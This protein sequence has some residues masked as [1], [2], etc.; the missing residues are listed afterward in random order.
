MLTTKEQSDDDVDDDEWHEKQITRK[1]FIRKKMKEYTDTFTVHGL[2]RVLTGTRYESI[3]WFFMLIG[4][5]VLSLIVVQGLT[6]KYLKRHVYVQISSK[7]VTEKKFPSLTICEERKL[8]HSYFEYCGLHPIINYV[9]SPN[10]TYPCNRQKKWHKSATIT[11]TNVSWSNGLFTVLYCGTW[12]NLNCR[13][14]QYLRSSTQYNDACVTW[15]YD[16]NLPGI[17][18]HAEIILAVK[19]DDNEEDQH[20]RENERL[21]VLP[22]DPRITEI[23]FTKQVVLERGKSLYMTL[24]STLIKRLPSPFPSKCEDAAKNDIFPGDYSRRSCIESHHFISMHK[25]CGD[26]LDYARQFIPEHI[27]AKYSQNKSI[28]EIIECIVDFSDDSDSI[29]SPVCPFPCEEL[30]LTTVN[31]F[32]KLRAVDVQ[33]AVA[34]ANNS[35]SSYSLYKIEFQYQ[36]VDSQRII[37]EMELYTLYQMAC[38]VGGFISLVLGSS[39][40]SFIEILSFFGLL[41]FDKAYLKDEL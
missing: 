13:S 18:G 4:S 32:N 16:G 31:N 23:D 1:R 26:T 14:S 37:E 40:L 5:M 12:G 20:H 41:I 33:T 15:N 30:E 34:W 10:L 36:R 19:F 21:I 25:K 2:S 9:D 17:Y 35:M 28:K 6:K 27:K 39:V 8:F 29:S 24:E 3:F 11:E 38:E 7:M 22:H